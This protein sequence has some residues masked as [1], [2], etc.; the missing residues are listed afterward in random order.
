VSALP[1]AF[2]LDS[3]P[4]EAHDIPVHRIVDERG[5]VANPGKR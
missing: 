3:V 5:I 2:I 1:S 4:H